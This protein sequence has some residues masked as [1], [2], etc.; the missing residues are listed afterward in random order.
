MDGL[1]DVYDRLINLSGFE[2]WCQHWT[3]PQERGMFSPLPLKSTK[4]LKG[5]KKKDLNLT[6]LFQ[7]FPEKAAITSACNQ[8]S[9]KSLSVSWEAFNDGWYAQ[10]RWRLDI[11]CR[12]NVAYSDIKKAIKYKFINPQINQRKDACPPR[13][14]DR[15]SAAWPVKH[16]QMFGMMQ[17]M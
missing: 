15:L 16:V 14:E 3:G 6:L 17:F 9:F 13:Q 8:L 11:R 7:C 4:L 1:T 5:G 10:N 2:L 12:F